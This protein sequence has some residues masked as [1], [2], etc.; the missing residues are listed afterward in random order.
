MQQYE[1]QIYIFH[2]IFLHKKQILTIHYFIFR[3]R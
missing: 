2:V 3:D 1:K